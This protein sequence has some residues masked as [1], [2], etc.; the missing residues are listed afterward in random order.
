MTTSHHT[1]HLDALIEHALAP[2]VEPKSLP[3]VIQIMREDLL[4]AG[5]IRVRMRPPPGT[6]GDWP[7]NELTEQRV[8]VV[9]LANPNTPEE[10]CKGCAARDACATWEC[11]EHGRG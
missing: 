1:T 5:E 6:V 11:P 8:L 4:A 2:W 9:P 7:L 3:I 10:R